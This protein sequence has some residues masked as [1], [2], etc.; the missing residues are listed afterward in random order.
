M[1]QKCYEEDYTHI[2]SATPGPIG[3]AALII[4]RI[5]KRP[6]C[7]TYHTALPEYVAQLTEDAAMEE[8]M[9]RYVLWYYNQMDLVYVPSHAMGE[10]LA[11]KGIPR[12]K[13]EF[14][15][16]GIDNLRFHPSKKNGFYKQRFDLKDDAIKLLYVGRVSKEKNITLL[17]DVFKRVCVMRKGVHLVIIG[18]G[19][20]FNEMQKRLEGLPVTFTGFL[21]GEDLS[22]AYASSD[23]FLFPSTTDTFGNVVL[24]A[25]ASGLP[26]VVT[27]EGGPKE[28]LVPGETGFVVP[29]SDADKFTQSILRLVDDPSLLETMK[30]KAREYTENR[31]FE[32]AYIELWNSH[33]NLA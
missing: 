3:I 18:E 26:V 30:K 13:I 4:A 19:P 29:A 21:G 27:D 33:R 9:W 8:I 10:E 5:L 20:Y 2:H 25:Q 22:Q 1:L 28:N 12:E 6:I 17:E 31:S 32:D 23:I 14:Y 11:N 7:G 16:R 24:E 15:P